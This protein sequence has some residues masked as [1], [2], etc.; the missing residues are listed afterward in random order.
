VPK[1]KNHLFETESDP[2]AYKHFLDGIGKSRGKT[3]VFAFTHGSENAWY[4]RGSEAFSVEMISFELANRIVGVLR[5]SGV[6]AARRTL[7]E[8]A[9]ASQACEP[10]V[11]LYEKIL[12]GLEKYMQHAKKNH[13]NL[14]TWSS[15]PDFGQ[16]IKHV[17]GKEKLTPEELKNLSRLSEI[18]VESIDLPRVIGNGQKGNIVYSK[19]VLEAIVRRKQGIVDHHALRGE[20][21]LSAETEMYPQGGDM[22]FSSYEKGRL[23][24]ISEIRRPGKPAVPEK[25]RDFA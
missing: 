1:D 8:M 21:Y 15:S 11:F 7:G 10:Y 6:E 13:E 23:F 17:Y 3:F 18:D 19:F 14:L 5:E 2:N 16:K 9:V 22:T 24:P 25:E 12:P 20:D 4:T